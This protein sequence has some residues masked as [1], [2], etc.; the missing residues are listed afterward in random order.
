[1]PATRKSSG[2][3]GHRVCRVL[4]LGFF[5]VITVHG[6]WPLQHVHHSKC[7]PLTPAGRRFSLEW[8][9]PQRL[10][11]SFKARVLPLNRAP[12]SGVLEERSG[13]PVAHTFGLG[14]YAVADGKIRDQRVA[15]SYLL[16]AAI[17]CFAVR[18]SM[19][20]GESGAVVDL[21]RLVRALVS[22]CSLGPRCFH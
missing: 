8:V 18:R 9:A 16:G 19:F 10:E 3:E 1:M 12:S 11:E 5:R 2:H 20:P 7:L 22:N 6:T 13:R 21:G 14:V 4:S 17:K 15:V